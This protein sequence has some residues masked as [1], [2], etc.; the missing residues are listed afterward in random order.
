M[1]VSPS[2]RPPACAV[3]QEAPWTSVKVPASLG[4]RQPCCQLG[5]GRAC[6]TRADSAATSAGHVFLQ[7]GD[8][9]EYQRIYTTKIKPRLRSEDGVEGDPGETQSRTITVTR[10]VTA[11]TVDVTGREGAKDID[12]SSP[13]FKIKIPRHELTEISTVGVEAQPGMTVIR[14][15][16]GSGAV[17][18]TTGSAVDIRAGSISASGP[19]LQGAGHS[20]IQVTVPGI[21]V[22]SPGANVSAKGLALGGK[23]GIQVPGVDVSS[24]LGGGAVELQGP[25]LE[26]GNNGKIKIP[27]MKVP[28]FGVPGG[29]EG[30]APEAGLAAF[31]PEFS[32]GHKEGKPGVTI[33]GNIQTPRLGVVAPSA[34]I[35]GLKGKLKGPQITGPSLEGEL[36]LKG[37]KPQGSIGVDI[38]APKMKGGITGPS[39]EGRASDMD[40]HGS[41]GKLNMPKTKVQKFSVS[42]SKG[43]GAGVDV[44][45][46]TGEVTL[47]GISGDV[48]LPKVGTGGLEG[49]LKGLS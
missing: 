7:S 48:S 44:T 39:V 20:K 41:G 46:P 24:S 43:E 28:K 15:P 25:S 23:G 31:T 45:L 34:N 49:K 13:E 14:L 35:E 4:D 8:D 10:R 1:A 9:E 17:S 19:E 21:K 3:P 32:V 2:H 40:I 29:P 33:G 12:I 37:A 47:P 18:P 38:S 42:G 22:G 27:A 5:C 36:G 16:S 6:V 11:Y 30:Q 26:N